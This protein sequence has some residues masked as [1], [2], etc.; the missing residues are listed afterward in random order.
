MLPLCHGKK[1]TIVWGE[2]SSGR[3]RAKEYFDELDDPDQ[4]K[5][6]PLFNRLST[7]GYITNKTRFT[8]EIDGIFCLKSGQHRLACFFDGDR[9]VIISGF[10]KKTMRDRRS[11]RNLET[12]VGLKDDYLKRN[13][14]SQ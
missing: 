6:E 5:F 10:E 4:A 9:V 14:D 7:D 12:A 13:G 8:K 2:D 3:H 11:V 1:R